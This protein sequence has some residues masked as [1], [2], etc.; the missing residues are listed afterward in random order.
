[1]KQIIV[2]CCGQSEAVPYP[3]PG[4]KMETYSYN[5]PM[6]FKETKIPEF[7]LHIM[8]IDRL[9]RGSQVT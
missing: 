8:T 1:M 7:P 4:I 5:I 6:L 9:L 3:T 2:V